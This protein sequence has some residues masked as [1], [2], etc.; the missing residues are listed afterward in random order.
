M[1]IDGDNDDVVSNELPK[2]DFSHFHPLDHW[3]WQS[4]CWS[5]KVQPSYS[6]PFK[7]GPW[8]HVKLAWRYKWRDRAL[9]PWFRQVLCRRG[10]HS[11]TMFDVSPRSR[12]RKAHCPHCFESRRMTPEELE[13][14]PVV[15]WPE[16]PPKEGT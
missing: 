6:V 15:W 10:Q 7:G 3:P 9:G 4:R 11:W 2:L 8:H 5:R 12:M 13:Q 14:H 16:E 1:T